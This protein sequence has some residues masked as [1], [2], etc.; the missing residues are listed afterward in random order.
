MISKRKIW[1][2]LWMV[3]LA[4][5]LIAT[6]PML[7]TG[8]GGCGKEEEPAPAPAPD[9][10]KQ[11]PPAPE[12]AVPAP[13][14]K[15]APMA[16]AAPGATPVT[17]DVL[18]LAPG[19]AM[20]SLALPPVSGLHEKGVAMAKRLVPEDVDVEAE[21]AK[22]VAQMAADA[23]VPDAK[24]LADIMRAKGLDP[25]APLAV[26][27]DFAPTA[28]SARK[29]LE[30]MKSTMAAPAEGEPQLPPEQMAT[31]FSDMTLPAMAGVLGCVD[32][33]L[34]EKTLKELVETEGSPIDASKL[35]AIDAGGVTIH[36]YDPEQLAYFVADNK[37]V[38]GNSLALL[39]ETA[40]RLTAPAAV[41]YG[42]AD[43]PAAAAD[44]VVMLVRGDKFMPLIKD[45]MPAWMGLSPATAGYAQM[46]MAMIEEAAQAFAGEDPLVM[47]LEWRDDLIELV[48]RIDFGTHPALAEYTGEVKP[49]RLA[50]LLPEGTL[51]LLSFQFNEVTKERIKKNYL[52]ALPPELEQ[53]EGFQEAKKYIDKVV[54]ALGDELT[55]AVTAGAGL[56]NLFLLAN[57]G[58]PEEAKSVIEDLSPLTPGETHEGVDISTLALPLPIPL[59]LAFPQDTIV[60]GNDKENLKIIIDHIKN[61]T[62]SGLF[63][64]LDPPLDPATPRYS[65][66]VIN[67]KLITDVVIPLSGLAGGI[68]PEAQT[69]VNVVTDILR[70]LRITK[71]QEGDWAE[72]R[73]SLFLKP[74][75]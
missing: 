8:C 29:A 43:C 70:E 46:H 67:T 55:I 16:K 58:N 42:S 71:E 20:V 73:V 17:L 56:P 3:T 2:G 22:Q 11:A 36:C 13:E 48:S 18:K 66:I 12:K 39:K 47:T 62:A 26:F 64:S 34:A 68:P 21:V 59:F 52:D 15:P 32:A 4:A 44:E 7:S 30:A 9:V 6:A 25:D 37:L 31:I 75:A 65:A 14:A 10:E 24:S 53:N 1:A 51:V 23:G 54:A 60:L 74:A 41:R 19:S 38:V 72:G 45:L 33:A 69:Y 50:P 57:L 40:G 28:A 63:A 61:K 27:A 49:L 5:V 35:E